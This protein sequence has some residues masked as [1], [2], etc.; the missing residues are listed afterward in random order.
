MKA[1]LALSLTLAAIIHAQPGACDSCLRSTC[2][3]NQNT[4]GQS[5]ACLPTNLGDT[6]GLCVITQRQQPQP[7]MP[8]PYIPRRGSSSHLL[9]ALRHVTQQR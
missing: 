7:P 2:V 6:Q 9:D 1:M 8:A 5:C 4:C 3:L